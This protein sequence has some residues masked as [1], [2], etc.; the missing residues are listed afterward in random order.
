L[1]IQDEQELVSLKA[2][3]RVVRMVLDAMKAEV[4]PGVTTRY[5]DEIGA[6][7]MRENGAFRSV[8][9]LPVSGRQL[10]QLER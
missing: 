5:L 2:A 1:S 6:S 8:D 3:G 10:H 7:V 4:R 9:G